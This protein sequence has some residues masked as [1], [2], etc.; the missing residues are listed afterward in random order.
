VGFENLIQKEWSLVGHLFQK[1]L[2]VLSLINTVDSN[3]EPNNEQEN[4][5]NSNFYLTTDNSDLKSDFAPTFLLFLDCVFQLIVQYP[6][7][8]EFNEFY[9]INLWDY[10]CCGLSLTFNFNGINDLLNCLK[11]R[12]MEEP[13][14]LERSFELN[15]LFWQELI[16][17]NETNNIKPIFLNK[18]FQSSNN[19]LIPCDKIYLLKFWSRCYLRWYESYYSYN[20]DQD[21]AKT[22]I[23]SDFNFNLEHKNMMTP[24]RPA[25]PPPLPPREKR[26]EKRSEQLGDNIEEL[27]SF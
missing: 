17:D 8:F 22:C 6:N 19:I 9:L 21:E 26:L 2:K 23:N 7:E 1:R 3:L 12:G 24:T 13:E 11:T 18:N 4:Q 27:T 10:S 25:P 16:T 5:P 14:N 15:V 20:L